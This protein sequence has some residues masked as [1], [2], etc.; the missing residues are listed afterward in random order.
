MRSLLALFFALPALAQA[1][2]LPVAQTETAR[3]KRIHE[4]LFKTYRLEMEKFEKGLPETTAGARNLSKRIS[5]ANQKMLKEM[6][7][8]K[9]ES[10]I[11]QAQAEAVRASISSHPIAGETALKGYDPKDKVGFC[12]GRAAYVH[13]EL[14]RR[15]LPPGSVGKVFALGPLKSRGE[16][17][18]FHVATVAKGPGKTW[19][20]LD[21]LA[22]TVMPVEEWILHTQKLDRDPKNPT[23]RFYFADAAKFQPHFG[24]YAKEQFEIGYLKAYF[25]DL[26]KWFQTNPASP[27]IR[28]P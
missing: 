2:T 8:E 14:L 4:N 11:S 25:S 6:R 9:A 5:Q 19:W 17:W 1:F 15:G 23:T 27:E 20:V 24:A 3:G 28:F 22:P 26:E 16:I 10:F 7:E 21:N 12:F 13:W 18:D